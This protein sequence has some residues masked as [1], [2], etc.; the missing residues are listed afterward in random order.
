MDFPNLIKSDALC[1]NCGSEAKYLYGITDVQADKRNVGVLTYHCLTCHD[2]FVIT[3]G[4]TTMR[5]GETH[6]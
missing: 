2:E 1:P 4:I 5:K 3:I 6:V